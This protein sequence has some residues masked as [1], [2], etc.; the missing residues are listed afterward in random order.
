MPILTFLIFRRL[1]PYIIH[2]HTHA[3]AHVCVYVSRLLNVRMRFECLVSHP[4][5][6]G[7]LNS[8]SVFRRSQGD[9]KIFE[10]MRHRFLNRVTRDRKRD[11]RSVKKKITLN[12]RNNI[13]LFV[14]GQTCSVLT[15]I[16]VG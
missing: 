13:T 15:S 8:T 9:S 16:P 14:G 1:L 7:Y 11:V 5:H 2:I 3:L 10:N 12:D 4:A 6:N